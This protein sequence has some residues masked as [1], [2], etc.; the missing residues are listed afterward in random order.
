MK[1]RHE[2]GSPVVACS[3][4]GPFLRVSV[5]SACMYTHVLVCVNL[6]DTNNNR[7]F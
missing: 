5:N 6:W 2:L 7:E 1:V 4:I 3:V